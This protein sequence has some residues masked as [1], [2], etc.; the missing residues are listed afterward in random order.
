MLAVG[1]GSALL[2]PVEMYCFYLFSEGGRFHYEGFGFGSF[3]FGNIACQIIGY[4][5][6]ALVLIPLGYGHLRLRRWARTLSV[7]L[8][9][10]WL[11]LGVPLSIVLFFILVTAKELSMAAVLFAI[12]LLASFY[13]VVPGLLI[14]FYKSRDVRSTFDK[15][16]KTYW[17]ERL[18]MPA[19]VLCSLYAFYIIALQ[20]LIFFNGIV[21]LFGTF[22][23]GLQGLILLDGLMACLVLLIWGTFKQKGWAWWGSLVFFALLALS[24]LWTLITSSYAQVLSI[25]KFAPIEMQALGGLPLQGL[26]LAI[27]VGIPLLATVGIIL[28]SRRHFG[29][30]HPARSVAAHPRSELSPHSQA[31]EDQQCPGFVDSYGDLTS[32]ES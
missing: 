7:T 11:V 19:L 9:W 15:D 25:T 29:A 12:V 20:G 21:P 16:P 3:M 1:I 32:G 2:G 26:H 4:Y 31:M 30:R 22:V 28:F 24:T 14:R 8:L 13:L 10:C 5:V 18:P 27:L 17:T 6:I 23:V